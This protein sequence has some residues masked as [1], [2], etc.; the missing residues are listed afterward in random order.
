MDQLST[1]ARWTM[2]VAVLIGFAA[3]VSLFWMDQM[4]T[5]MQLGAGA[6]FVV[7]MVVAYAVHFSQASVRQKLWRHVAGQPGQRFSIFVQS[8]IDLL[9]LIGLIMLGNR[10]G[11]DGVWHFLLVFPLWVVISF[12]MYRS[13]AIRG[14][15]RSGH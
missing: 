13:R 9:M 7:G 2:R 3:L 12:F 8:V 1:R 14:R 15:H 5:R 10:M 6:T 4:S 11:L